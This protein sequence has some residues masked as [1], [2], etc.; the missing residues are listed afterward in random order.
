MG[1]CLMI[2][3]KG[4]RLSHE[5]KIFIEKHQIGGVILFQRNCLSYKNIKALCCEIRLLRTPSPV[6]I[7]IDREGGEVDRLKNIPELLRWPNAKELANKNSLKAIEQSSYHLHQELREIGIHVNFS[8][9]LD[10]SNDNSQ[11]LRHRTFSKN[12]LLVSQIGKAIIQGAR[13]AGVLSCGK[14]F[15]GHGGVCED[16]HLETPVDHRVSSK[17]MEG[18]IP[19]RQAISS[20]LSTIMM[21]HVLYPSL[22]SIHLASCSQTIIQKILKN[23]LH[24]SGL[25]FSDDI[26]MKSVKCPLL[27]T[28]KALLSGV[29]FLICGN[30]RQTIKKVLKMSENEADLKQVIQKRQKEIASFTS[31]NHNIF[32]KY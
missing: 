7:A 32:Y 4:E 8:P 23:Q 22:D 2:G 16:S 17:I 27:F 1:P 29:H 5:E 13:R 26:D 12:P 11:V 14:H 19:F 15:P 21:A 3:I 28:K 20:Q 18:M 10:I 25:I 30:D 6:W 24:F 31:Q 9:C